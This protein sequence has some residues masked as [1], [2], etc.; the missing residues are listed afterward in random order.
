MPPPAV[1]N[2]RPQ[3]LLNGQHVPAVDARLTEM[4][5]THALN[6][7]AHCHMIFNSG[8][9]LAAGDIGAFGDV[10]HID[11]ETEPTRIFSSAVNALG[12]DFREDTPPTTLLAADDSLRLLDMRWQTR[13]F[14]AA[15]DRD[16]IL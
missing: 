16:A 5:V 1:Y 7:P 15:R 4:V 10:L 6:Q 9:S 8:T 11:I 12:A 14:T 2:L 13:V 3:I